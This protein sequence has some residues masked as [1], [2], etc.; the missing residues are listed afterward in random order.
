M[1]VDEIDVSAKMSHGRR[2]GRERSVDVN[3]AWTQT[4]IWAR[5]RAFSSRLTI[6]FM[7]FFK[8]IKYSKTPP[9]HLFSHYKQT[10]IPT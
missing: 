9:S 10:S 6:G 1:Y 8:V 2:S 4:R 5:D 3:F 7:F